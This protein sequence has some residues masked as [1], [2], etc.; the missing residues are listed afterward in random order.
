[1]GCAVNRVENGHKIYV[2]V[3]EDRLINGAILPRSFV[4]ENGQRY[5]VDK[6]ISVSPTS[7]LKTGSAGWRY[8]VRIRGRE[9]YMFLEEDGGVGRWF[10]EHKS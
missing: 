6:V 2:E 7:N 4:W 9:R 3:N 1:M 8:T 10:M 5:S